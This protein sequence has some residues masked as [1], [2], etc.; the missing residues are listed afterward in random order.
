[1]GP[2]IPEMQREHEARL[3]ATTRWIIAETAD[4]FEVHRWTIDGVAPWAV[5]ETKE[6]AAARLI[7]LMDIR[8]AIIPQA[9]PEEVMIGT[10]E[11][12]QGDD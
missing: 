1:M 2:D 3:R 10:V 5:K 4:G 7:Q 6:A 8:H 12:K 9:Y 11:P